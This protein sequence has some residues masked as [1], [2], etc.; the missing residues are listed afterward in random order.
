M[1]NT[2]LPVNAIKMI[3]YLR[4]SIHSGSMVEGKRIPSI[5]AL[6]NEFDVS[7]GS[8]KRAL[9]CLCGM[10]LIETVPGKGTFV[11]SLPSYEIPDAEIRLMVFL[12]WSENNRGI[13][14]EIFHSLQSEA[15]QKGYSLL[16]TYLGYDLVSNEEVAKISRGT[17][18]IIMLGEYDR[19]L[20]DLTLPIPIVAA[21]WHKSMNGKVSIFDLDPFNAAELAVQYFSELGNKKVCIFTPDIPALKNR[22]NLFMERWKGMGKEAEIIMS[23]QTIDFSGLDLNCGYLFTSGWLLQRNSE[24]YYE[25]FGQRLPE[26]YKTLGI[27]GRSLI[28]HTCHP[29]PCIT[30]DWRLM[31]K[32][33]IEECVNR[34]KTPG[35]VPVRTYFPCTLCIP[36]VQ[37]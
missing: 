3:D 20:E 26:V 17:N 8:A 19:T 15:V 30:T 33:I 32:R 12:L 29:T 21:E 35:R 5:R 31:G 6:M 2:T 34:I 37:Q 9:D 1:Q 18:G 25:Q 27:D 4:E 28:D 36:K 23:E 13:F 16:F 24:K 7:L 22:A 11:K 10:N 14:S